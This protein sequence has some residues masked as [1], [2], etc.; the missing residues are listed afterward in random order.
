MGD[1]ID[2]HRHFE[3][4]GSLVVGGLP[5]DATWTD[6]VGNLP[7]TSDPRFVDVL[8]PDGLPATGDED[9]RPAPGSPLY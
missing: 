3:V 1:N 7:V 9:L 8:G 4:A 2:V 6:G 5:P